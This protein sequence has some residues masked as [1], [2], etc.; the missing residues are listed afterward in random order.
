ME[1]NQYK[2]IYDNLFKLLDDFI[3]DCSD[4]EN[5]ILELRVAL[6][7]RVDTCDQILNDIDMRRNEDG[8]YER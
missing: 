4:D 6:K 5:G 7:E 3:E 1:T 8:D 2:E